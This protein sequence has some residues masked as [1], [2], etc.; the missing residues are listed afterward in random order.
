MD[1]PRRIDRRCGREPFFPPLR[2]LSS[3]A[4]RTP[5]HG[6]SPDTF[7][8]QEPAIEAAIQAGRQKINVSFEQA[9]GVAKG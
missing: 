7:P 9:S 8:T 1:K 3:A 5:A 6:L 4:G 2:D